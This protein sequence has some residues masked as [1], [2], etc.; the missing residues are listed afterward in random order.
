MRLM[1]FSAERRRRQD[2][3]A[4]FVFGVLACT[5][6]L[7]LVWKGAQPY[8]WGALQG[9]MGPMLI[10]TLRYV[11]RVLTGRRYDLWAIADAVG[12]FA[13]FVTMMFKLFPADVWHFSIVLTCLIAT[14][15]GIQ[16]FRYTP[17]FMLLNCM[18]VGAVLL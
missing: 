6:V 7:G 8:C 1:S 3:Q 12:F 13:V 16:K 17:I 10:I 2:N 14:V 18:I 11:F 4:F 5:F 9:A 15:I